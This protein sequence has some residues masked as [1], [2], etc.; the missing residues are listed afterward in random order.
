MA[1]LTVQGIIYR[2]LVKRET[3]SKALDGLGSGIRVFFPRYAK[4]ATRDKATIMVS[5][6]PDEVTVA[7]ERLK[8]SPRG[9]GEKPVNLFYS[10]RPEFFAKQQLELPFRNLR[11]VVRAA[12]VCPEKAIGFSE[13]FDLLKKN[14]PDLKEGELE[15]R[16]F[17]MIEKKALV[18]PL[19]HEFVLQDASLEIGLNL[20]LGKEIYRIFGT[21]KLVSQD[22]LNKRIR[23][24]EMVKIYGDNG[25]T[26]V[27]WSDLEN[28]I[29]EEKVEVAE[30][31]KGEYQYIWKEQTN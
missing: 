17:K 9:R 24:A 25:F 3:L 7:L 26:P 18:E 22:G 2:N 15:E 30:G 5:A 8:N 14:M 6:D 29:K 27:R 10:L 12:L 23:L 21:D 1:N 11:L 13:L 20:L 16:V 31:G 19:A 28:L 4:G